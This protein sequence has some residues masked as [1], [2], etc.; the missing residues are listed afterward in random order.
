MTHPELSPTD[1]DDDVG[2]MPHNRR[3]LE[4]GGVREAAMVTGRL[5][6]DKIE[7]DIFFYFFF[8]T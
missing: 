2:E 1:N 4:P 5:T 7:E 8:H 3:C 6:R